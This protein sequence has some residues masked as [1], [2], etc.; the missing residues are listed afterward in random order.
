ME[1]L[2]EAQK[3]KITAWRNTAERSCLDCEEILKIMDL[4]PNRPMTV[5]EAKTILRWD[6]HFLRLKIE[7]A[8][9]VTLRLH[10]P[11]IFPVDKIEELD[12]AQQAITYG[13]KNILGSTTL[14][15][16]SVLQRAGVSLKREF[17]G[18]YAAEGK[19]SVTDSDY[20]ETVPEGLKHALHD[21]KI[22]KEH[23]QDYIR[24]LLRTRA[25]LIQESQHKATQ[26]SKDQTKIKDISDELA[27]ID[28]EV[29]EHARSKANS[30]YENIKSN[31]E[32]LDVWLGI[33]KEAYA[34]ANKSVD[35]FLDKVEADKA[36][37][38]QIKDDIMKGFVSLAMSPFL[39]NY[40][41]DPAL[42]VFSGL[43]SQAS[44]LAA[45]LAQASTSNASNNSIMST[46]QRQF[47]TF[48][49]IVGVSAE[50]QEETMKKIDEMREKSP[51]E[52]V[53]L[54]KRFSDYK[55]HGFAKDMAQA[56]DA[57]ATV[58]NGH[59]PEE[60]IRSQRL[61]HIR[62]S[63][64]IMTNDE[65]E[66]AKRDD[67]DKFFK[68]TKRVLNNKFDN[69]IEDNIF[70]TINKQYPD[71][72]DIKQLQ[73][74]IK[75][76]SYDGKASGIDAVQMSKRNELVK[77]MAKKIEISMIVKYACTYDEFFGGN[78]K[79]AINNI[80]LI[81]SKKFDPYENSHFGLK[82]DHQ[83]KAI[84]DYLIDKLPE[85]KEKLEPLKKLAMRDHFNFLWEIKTPQKQRDRQA[86][87]N[88]IIQ[89]YANGDLS[90][91]LKTEV[92]K[93]AQASNIV[94]RDNI[95][96]SIKHQ[97]IAEDDLRAEAQKSLDPFIQEADKYCA[98]TSRQ[99]R[100]TR[101]V[102][103]EMALVENTPSALDDQPME[104]VPDSRC[105]LEI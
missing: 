23:R 88:E 71:K 32:A 39:L 49:S 9:L 80:N 37:R 67:F 63:Q 28:V 22:Q 31:H 81:A 29:L 42:L 19:S 4:Q 66:E 52:F 7:M 102:V 77:A 36:R 85:K 68:K 83:G 53:E 1:T 6:I 92:F 38:K 97:W 50:T 103:Q 21:P 86:V 3:L 69:V 24:Q 70:S 30:L 51:A 100:L 5:G 11:I 74:I 76:V 64:R 57:N 45:A 33:V 35:T 93:F 34:V 96:P 20:T 75:L 79:Q 14:R 17:G 78:A 104:G 47:F 84:I 10:K 82:A 99:L 40:F 46:L 27:S 41:V 101:Q 89:E 61:K 65:W 105:L 59:T 13:R 26:E 54:M 73:N 43:A 18:L 56:F 94:L 2:N 62:E 60:I 95:K 58:W 16:I 90:S 25:K 72:N 15:A 55:L 48:L 44:T 8:E 12:A 87:L 91:Q 98:F